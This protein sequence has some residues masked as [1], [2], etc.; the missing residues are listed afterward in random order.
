MEW[1]EHK[2]SFRIMPMNNVFWVVLAVLLL[3][4][5]SWAA[6]RSSGGEI[7]VGSKTFTLVR[8]SRCSGNYPYGNY[9]S[10]GSFCSG[11]ACPSTYL[12]SGRYYAGLVPYGGGSCDG[13]AFHCIP[14]PGLSFGS[15]CYNSPQYYC[16]STTCRASYECDTQRDADSV[17]CSFDGKFWDSSTG[18]CSNSCS[19]CEAF[20]SACRAESGI[21]TGSCLTSGGSTCCQGVCDVCNGE[22]MDKLYK[23]KTNQCCEQGLAPPEKANVCRNQ[24]LLE[25]IQS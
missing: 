12:L 13:S 18:N 25:P 4:V 21:F 10:V 5:S 9:A 22:A 14:S 16:G 23:M 24:S 19:Q 11:I 15:S 2:G 7:P 20:E 17:Q 6:C 3:S 8:D 1:Q